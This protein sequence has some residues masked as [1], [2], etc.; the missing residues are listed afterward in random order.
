MRT[1]EEQKSVN[2]V[3]YEGNLLKQGRKNMDSRFPAQQKGLEKRS[4]FGTKKKDYRTE[5]GIKM[6]RI[7]RVFLKWGAIC[8]NNPT[9]YLFP[10]IQRRDTGVV[11]W[12]HVLIDEKLEWV[13]NTEPLS[14]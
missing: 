9:T 13:T 8:P 7:T 1:D 2:I 4:L 5:F 11:V 10:T 3:F 6:C 12:V 14:S